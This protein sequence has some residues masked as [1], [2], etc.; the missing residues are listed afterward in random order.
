[1]LSYVTDFEMAM[2]KYG[3]VLFDATSSGVVSCNWMFTKSED[4][5]TETYCYFITQ[6]T[7]G[8]ILS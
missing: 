6:W 4:G 3:V 2:K 5:R 1:M 7:R 8:M